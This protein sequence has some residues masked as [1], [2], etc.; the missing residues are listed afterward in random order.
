MNA[1]MSILFALALMAVLPMTSEGA[2]DSPQQVESLAQ[3]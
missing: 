1:L 3:S 2:E